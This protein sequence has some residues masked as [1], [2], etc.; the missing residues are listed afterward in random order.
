LRR[1]K[2]RTL[3]D[4]LLWLNLYSLAFARRDDEEMRHLVNDAA[5]K[6]GLEDALL[7]MQSDTEAYF[8]HLKKSRE[9]SVRAQRVAQQNGDKETAAGYL[10]S[11]ALREVEIGDRTKTH[12]DV[13]EA[14][15][16]SSGRNVRTLAALALARA[17]EVNRAQSI[18]ADVSRRFPSDTLINSL[19]A[20]TIRAA[21]ELNRGNVGHASQFL[22]AIS[23]YELAPDTYLFSIYLR[24]EIFLKT[25]QGKES[26]AEFQKILNNP[27]V[28]DNFVLGSL[29]HLGLARAY[30]LQRDTAKAN[31]A[32][33]EFLTLWKDADSDIPI[34]IAA[35]AEYAKLK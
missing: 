28:V 30:V 16:M 10:V 14:L 22:E 1:V 5:A 12:R 11:A 27:G 2:A 25:S 35:K 21:I 20:P 8:G 24:G 34:L 23:D 13:A 32:Y 29:A 6:P 4:E 19:W 18:A 17:G 7:G 26:A 33:Q 3:N 31:E 9:L 15:A